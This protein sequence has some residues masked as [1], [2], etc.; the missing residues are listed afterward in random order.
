[1]V[2]VLAKN[3]VPLMPTQNYGYVRVLLKS[4]DAVVVRQKPFTIRL[5]YT[6]TTYTQPLVCGIDPG[7]TNIGVAVVTENGE[8]VFSANADTHNKDVPKRMAER[9]AHRQASR[10]GERL[11]RQRRAKAAG[12]C[13]TEGKRQRILPG[14]KEPITCKGIKNSE[15]RFNNRK[16]KK[17]WLTPTAN[18][19]LQSHL[20]LLR[21]VKKILPISKVVLELNSFDFMAMEN[22]NI[23]RWQYQRGPLYGKGSVKDAVSMSQ[24]GTCLFCSHSIQ[25]YHHIVPRS[26]GG[27]NTLPN[28][29]GLCENHHK[30]IHTDSV[31]QSKIKSEKAGRNKKYGALSVLNQIIP[32]LTEALHEIP[33]IEVCV[34]DGHSTKAFRDVHQVDKDH[35]LD[36]YC[37]AC[38]V[39]GDS[40]TVAPPTN[41]YSLRRFRRHDRAAVSRQEERKY[42]LDSKLVARNRHKRTEQT[43][44]SLTEFRNTNPAD[45]GKLHV[46]KGTAKY[47]DPTR[48]RPGAIFLVNGKQML[49]QGSTGKYKGKPVYYTFVGHSKR[50]LATKCALL[51]KSG[52]WQFM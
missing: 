20:T 24:G 30:L 4:H 21:L 52:G 47:K 42:Y 27:S 46:I 44:D 3:G 5:K 48:I 23:Q 6:T 14:C 11:R 49:F 38:S 28:I 35:H 51:I 25:H 13:F 9:K 12:T 33:D 7:R 37:I 41:H 18:H 32:A 26:K 31:W 2:Y 17:G 36:A 19:L 15:A 43:A 10:H 50:I 40:I 39:L 8:C 29:V 22:P 16:R 1:M 34:T 45:I